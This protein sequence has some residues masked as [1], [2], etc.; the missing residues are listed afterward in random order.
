MYPSE[1]APQCRT[2]VSQRADARRGSV[3]L[4]LAAQTKRAN[5]ARGLRDL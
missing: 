5:A 3:W 2:P 1:Y 4:V